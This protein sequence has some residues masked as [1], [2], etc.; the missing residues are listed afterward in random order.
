MSQHPANFKK[1]SGWSVNDYG[2]KWIDKSAILS[3]DWYDVTLLYH[4][5]AIKGR[6]VRYG[7][8]YGQPR[9]VCGMF[10]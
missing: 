10:Y 4:D 9:L 3:V 7:Q 8:M 2:C 5:V 1:I 6:F